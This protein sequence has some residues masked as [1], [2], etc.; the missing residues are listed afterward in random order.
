VSLADASKRF[1]HDHPGAA[2]A[3][4]PLEPAEGVYRYRGQGS[5]HLSVPPLTQAHGPD[6]PATVTHTNESCWTFRLDYSS[7]HWQD[8]EYC[9]RGGGLDELAGHTFQRWDLGLS[10]IDNHSEFTCTSTTLSPG[11]QPGDEWRQTCVG[12]N[13]TISGSTT[14][15]GT[16]RFVG[17][18]EVRVG[19]QLVATYHLVQ[20]R[21][22][23]GGQ[24]GTL[25]ADVWFA[26]DGL[27]VRER[28]V[29]SVSTS[30]PIGSIDY[31]ESTDF[32]LVALTPRS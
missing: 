14:S 3:G 17:I 7:N 11:M 12:R 20:R 9:P 18:E 21:T 2:Q 1:H 19:R 10:T 16:M 25:R 8:W 5:D 13:D 28:H 26:P 29:I 22:V 30:S 27:P 6:M 24:N 32:S 31:E 23:S 4:G 15:T